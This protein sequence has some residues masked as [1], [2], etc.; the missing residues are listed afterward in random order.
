M[1]HPCLSYENLQLKHENMDV[2]TN[3]D[4]EVTTIALL[5]CYTGKRKKLSGA[6]KERA[7]QFM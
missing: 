7:I 4:T 2:D 3:N 5:H 6:I 1:A